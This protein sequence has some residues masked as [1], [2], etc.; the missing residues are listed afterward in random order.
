MPHQDPTER[1]RNFNEVAIGWDRETA[2]AEA[3]RCLVCKK[4][5]CVANCPAEIDIPGFIQKI[6]GGQFLEAARI[7]RASSALPAV[8]G[9]VCPQ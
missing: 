4:P 2:V 3:R 6:S 1:V 8:C 5:Q 7:L 9:R